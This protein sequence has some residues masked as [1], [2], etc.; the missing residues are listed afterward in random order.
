LA[1]FRF[2][3]VI[4]K[5]SRARGEDDGTVAS[6]P[7]ACETFVNLGMNLQRESDFKGAFT[8]YEYDALDRVK[9]IRDRKDQIINI[10]NSDNN[11]CSGF[12]L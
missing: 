1:Q 6:G 12:T 7:I 4:R 2:F 8:V 3:R 9:L 11:G 5:C 10:A